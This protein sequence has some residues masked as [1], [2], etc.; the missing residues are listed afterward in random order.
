MTELIEHLTPCLEK[1][2]HK[3]HPSWSSKIGDITSYPGPRL[4]IHLGGN[5][6]PDGTQDVKLSFEVWPGFLTIQV[7]VFSSAD[8]AINI[9]LWSKMGRDDSRTEKA[10]LVRPSLE[11]KGSSGHILDFRHLMH[12]REFTLADNQREYAETH[13]FSEAHFASQKVPKVEYE[14]LWAAFEDEKKNYGGR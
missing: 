5:D 7:Q 8:A 6:H 11:I 2:G 14:A 1:K 13:G 9:S 10:M 12:E 4:F 3:S